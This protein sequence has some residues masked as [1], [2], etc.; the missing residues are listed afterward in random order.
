MIR[1]A[2]SSDASALAS[3]EVESWRE[4]YQGLL[5]ASHLASLDVIARTRWW[6][7]RIKNLDGVSGVHVGESGRDAVGFV[8][9]G[10]AARRG[11]GEI[12][13]VYVR[14]DRWRAGY[15]GRLLD[16]ALVA[17][18]RHGFSRVE[19]WVI[20]DNFAARSFYEAMGWR[21]AAG[22]RV[23]SIGGVDVNEARYVHET[24]EGPPPSEGPRGR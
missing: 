21:A 20:R 7:K 5:P 2:R 4:A 3:I 6:A 10:P 22:I 24:G 11:W 18:G 13:A 16:A 9:Y 12:F 14:P 23:E 15:G 8:S 1:S 19:L 17:L